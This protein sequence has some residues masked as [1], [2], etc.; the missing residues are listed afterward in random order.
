MTPLFRR[1]RRTARHGGQ[2]H[3]T[4]RPEALAALAARAQAQQPP[5]T[6]ESAPGQMPA[7]PD[8]T[9]PF[10]LAAPWRP[11]FPAPA[12]VIPFVPVTEEAV[13]YNALGGDAKTARPCWYCGTLH[14]RGNWSWRDDDLGR[15]SCPPCQLRPDWRAPCLPGLRIL[16]SGEPGR[17]EMRLM[18]H[19]RLATEARNIRQR[20]DGSWVAVIPAGGRRR[21]VGPFGSQQEAE[22]AY[23]YVLG[24]FAVAAGTAVSA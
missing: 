17:E 10:T 20:P 2:S 19:A 12:G 5:W 7:S 23:G 9:L 11:Y 6:G 21:L 8:P 3:G 1:S 15:W 4:A 22:A 14:Q 24:V 18:A 13:V 16:A